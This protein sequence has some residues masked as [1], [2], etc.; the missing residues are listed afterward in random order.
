MFL[1]FFVASVSFSF[2]L[3][4]SNSRSQE[5]AGAYYVKPTN[6]ELFISHGSKLFCSKFRID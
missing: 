1:M 5:L 4:G 3:C 6:M 2:Q